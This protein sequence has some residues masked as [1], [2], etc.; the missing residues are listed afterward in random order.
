MRFWDDML[1]KA[2]DQKIKV[3]GECF[4]KFVRS[5]H[6]A[7]GAFIYVY[8]DSST[9]CILYLPYLLSFLLCPRDELVLND[10]TRGDYA[11]AILTD[12]DTILGTSCE[13]HFRCIT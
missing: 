4:C 8:T 7:R 13:R 3:N 2:K 12:A 6:R 1:P 10:G 11:V 5:P 9:Q